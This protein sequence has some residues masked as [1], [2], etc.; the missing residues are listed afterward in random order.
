MEGV[1][2]CTHLEDK[3]HSDGFLNLTKSSLALDLNVDTVALMSVTAETDQFVCTMGDD[4][5]AG[6]MA[7]PSSLLL[8]LCLVVVMMNV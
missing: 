2:Y 5:G 8:I 3:V 7:R 6:Y 1:N 4:K